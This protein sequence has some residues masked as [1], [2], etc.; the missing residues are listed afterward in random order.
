MDPTESDLSHP[1]I[2]L[3]KYNFWYEPSKLNDKKGRITLF[4]LIT[5]WLC[6]GII[7][8]NL[9]KLDENSIS[10]FCK[11]IISPG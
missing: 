5:L 9:Q 6:D 3:T 11:T 7:T 8:I 4:I 2:K 1:P 10:G